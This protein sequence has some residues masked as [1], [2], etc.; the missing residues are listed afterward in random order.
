MVKNLIFDMGGVVFD[1]GYEQAVR[2]FEEIGVRDARAQLDPCI[3]SGIFGDLEGGRISCE[4]FRQGLSAHVGRDLTTE[5]CA[6]AWKG[7]ILDLPQRNLDK[8]LELRSRGYRLFLLSNTNPFIT[9]W[10]HSPQFSLAATPAG[11]A[12]MGVVSPA[13]SSS[14][15]LLPG[16]PMD[17]YFEK[18]YF[19]CDLKMMKP[20]PAIFRHVLDAEGLDPAETLFIDD[21]PRNTEAATLLGI[22][23]MCPRNN[24]DW[25]S[26]IEAYL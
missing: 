7:Y 2:R 22:R 12:A 10:A 25:T 9:Q 23:T 6:Y 5:E 24:A 17:H 8:L 18:L 13:A 19:S 1:L 3:Q 14:N 20:D 21:S 15:G 26:D 11:L 16:W 4:E